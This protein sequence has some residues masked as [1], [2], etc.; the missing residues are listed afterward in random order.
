MHTNATDNI[1][2]LA[3]LREV[4]EL[5][6]GAWQSET[7]DNYV[8]E[9]YVQAALGLQSNGSPV[10]SVETLERLKGLFPD[11]FHDREMVSNPNAT[12]LLVSELLD[13]TWAAIEPG[14]YLVEAYSICAQ[15]L[16]ESGNCR[17]GSQMAS[18]LAEIQEVL[19]KSP[20]P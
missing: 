3:T 6:D 20:A 14:N 17:P 1:S 2:A 7:A 8:V 10:P 18:R 4:C 11:G 13:G 12:L 5:L 19:Q 9:A 15:N 16:V